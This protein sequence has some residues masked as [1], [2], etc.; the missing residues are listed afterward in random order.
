M[1]IFEEIR[2]DH[3][4]QRTLINLLLETKG[5]SQG[6]EESWPKL[7]REMEQHAI[8]EERY[9]YN[10]L[11][12]HDRTQ[13]MARHSIAEHHELDEFIAKLDDMDMSASQWLITAKELGHMLLHHLEEE[14][15]E[16]FQQAGHA[17]S[18]KE[19]EKLAEQ[20]R[21]FLNQAMS[22]S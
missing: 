1:N 14:E 2:K 9:F 19:K 22:D 7:K 16:I 17:L 10:P 15:Q 20:Y 4:T 11:I 6:R 12:K 21:G 8:A 3:E 18:D 5:A 13:E